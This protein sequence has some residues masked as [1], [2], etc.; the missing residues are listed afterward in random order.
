MARV[1][2]LKK[3]DTVEV[4]AGSERTSKKNRGQI[5]KIDL[6]RSR[7]IVQGINFTKKHQRQKKQDVQGGII[8]IE[9]PIELSNLMFVCPKCSKTTRL[10]VRRVDG[11]RLRVC[12]RCGAEFV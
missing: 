11:K 3:G 12:K 5:L 9:A 8:E 2:R 4:V 10:G 7:A 6:E 1:T